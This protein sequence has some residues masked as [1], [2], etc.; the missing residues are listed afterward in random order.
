MPDSHHLF[1]LL[2]GFW[3]GEGE[4]AFSASPETVHY[5]TKWEIHPPSEGKIRCVQTVEMQGIKEHVTNKFT[6]S[7][8]NREG[9]TILLENDMLDKI[10]GKGL[11]DPKKIA[12]EFRD[13]ESFEGFEVYDLQENGEYLMHAEYASPDQFRTI[14]NGRIWKKSE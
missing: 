3:V 10:I 6:L 5:F 7:S 1:L 11:I 14:I 2:P 9:F 13:H 4:V 8:V 12:W